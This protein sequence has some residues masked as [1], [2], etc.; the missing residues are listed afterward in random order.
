MV[1]HV[2]IKRP[3]SAPKRAMRMLVLASEGAGNRSPQS[4]LYI[5]KVSQLSPTV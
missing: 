3:A 2:W 5:K 1:L 4:H